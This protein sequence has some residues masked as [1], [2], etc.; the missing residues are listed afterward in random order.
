MKRYK[1]L[2]LK[3][4]R[5]PLLKQFVSAIVYSWLTMTAVGLIYMLLLNH[6]D[7]KTNITEIAQGL[8]LVCFIIT[9]EKFPV[10]LYVLLMIKFFNILPFLISS[11]RL[12]CTESCIFMIISLVM[13]RL[14]FPD[15]RLSLLVSALSVIILSFILKIYLQHSRK[16][17]FFTCKEIANE[18]NK[19]YAINKEVDIFIITI[20]LLTLLGVFLSC[21]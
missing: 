7:F 8:T 1:T 6:R 14:F 4:R 3:A 21:Q 2:C 11:R 16:R 9:I 12:I 5:T 17:L 19:C 10:N 18:N 20:I 13:D 15:T